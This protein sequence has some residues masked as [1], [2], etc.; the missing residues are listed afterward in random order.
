PSMQTFSRTHESREK[1][2]LAIRR[3]LL[4]WKLI[5]DH[6]TNASYKLRGY[7]VEDIKEAGSLPPLLDFI[8]DILRIASGKPLDA[9]RF[10][11]KEFTVGGGDSL[12]R[13]AQR[14]SV[15]LYYLC[16]L[17]V[18]SLV[19]DWF[20]EQNRRIKSPLEVWTQ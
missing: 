14:L 8:C 17:Y 13:E 6:F 3:H 11:I 12:E 10:D 18:P 2:W 4:S 16:L 20:I 7:Y 5:M 15:H 1:V 9:S 19:K